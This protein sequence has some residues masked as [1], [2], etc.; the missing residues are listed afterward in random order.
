[1]ELLKALLISSIAVLAPIHAVMIVVGILIGA[2]LIL[3]IAASLK[4]GEK[5]HSAAMRRTVSKIL[6]YQLAV[7]TGFLCETY[8]MGGL[9]PISKLV[10]G[11]IGLVEMKSILENCDII[12]GE[13]IF[14]SVLKKL[15][16]D[17]DK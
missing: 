8:L 6:I 3:G 15:G 7:I 5:I 17:N 11:V 14:K 16:S 10:A 4:S 2:D 9:L 1:M 13:P 12:N